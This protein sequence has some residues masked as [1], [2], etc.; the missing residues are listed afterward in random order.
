MNYLAHAFLSF[1]H[2]EILLG[3]MI[4]DFVKGRKKFD[5]PPVVQKGIALHRAIDEFTDNHH[6]T[7]KAKTFFKPSYGLYSGAFVDIVYDYFLAN[8]AKEFGENKLAVFSEQTYRKLKAQ[9]VS[10]PEKF[11]QAFYYMQLHN[12]L[13]NYQFKEAIRKS[14]RGLVHRASYMHDSSGAD[15]IFED[16]LGELKKCYDDFF[17]LLKEFSYQQFTRLLNEG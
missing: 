12:W 10:F 8:D 16:N 9:E 6:A 15:L 7:K 17:P 4:S 14:F 5:Y 2:P 11:H 1:D 13:Y 3:N